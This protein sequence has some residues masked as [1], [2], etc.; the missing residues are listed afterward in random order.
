MHGENPTPTT[1]QRGQFAGPGAD[2]NFDGANQPP[3]LQAFTAEVGTQL[4]EQ[5]QQ[6]E[7]LGSRIEII[8]RRV[9]EYTES[10][11]TRYERLATG[12]QF[13]EIAEQLR[14]VQ[15]DVSR[16]SQLGTNPVEV[17]NRF[18]AH[19]KSE[20]FRAWIQDARENG[21]VLD[22]HRKLPKDRIPHLLQPGGQYSGRMGGQFAVEIDASLVGSLDQSVRRP[23]VIELLR[24][25]IGLMD[26]VNIVEAVNSRTVDYVRET[27]QSETGVIGTKLTAAIDGDPTPK[28]TC[29]VE[30]SEGF[31]SGVDVIFYTTGG[32][33][34]KPL[35]S[36]D[37]A[38][39][40][41]TFATNALDFD[42]AAGD[43][44]TTEEMLA[45]AEGARK[46]AGLLATED[47]TLQL[48]TIATWVVTTVQRLVYSNVTNL[49]AWIERRLPQR[50]REAME[51]HLIHGSGTN[52]ELHG[53]LNAAILPAGNT[54]TWSTS[55]TTGDTRADLVLFSA[56][57]IPGDERT[58]AVLNKKDWFRIGNYKASDGH[59]VQNLAEGPRIIDTPGLKAIGSVQV[60]LSR[61]MPETNGLVFVPEAASEVI[62]G[63]LSAMWTGFV[64]EGR[65]DNEVTH[66][67][68]AD[69]GNAIKDSRAF[70]KVVFDNPPA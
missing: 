45:T 66:L 42:A 29:T 40:V 14:A 17:L 41:L 63:A 8:E 27:E 36:K 55:L 33:E 59:Y 13:A 70:R 49:A 67:Y 62:P 24:D 54:D 22:E 37:D 56:C 7:E 21:G 2:S 4:T 5:R 61:K 57:Q 39:G 10:E 69:A 44:V 51:W 48:Q 11:A 3:G 16:L 9:Q 65:L 31:V 52:N 19:V 50:W 6:T 30:N 47:L 23:G 60:V 15:A 32:I 34:T 1:P 28:T 43:T 25:P 64:G 38:T 18:V 46:P 26:V 68:E 12:D 53:F 20:A 35:V 58:V